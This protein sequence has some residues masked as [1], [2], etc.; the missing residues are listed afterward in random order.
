MVLHTGS[1]EVALLQL[2]FYYEQ[3][4]PSQLL[5]A[6]DKEA[7]RTLFFFLLIQLQIKGVCVTMNDKRQRFATVTTAEL[8]CLREDAVIK[9]SIVLCVFDRHSRTLPSCPNE[10]YYT[11]MP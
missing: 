8:G 7:F 2:I 6:R 3:K 5:S 9:Y 11:Q 10:G 1:R 4:V